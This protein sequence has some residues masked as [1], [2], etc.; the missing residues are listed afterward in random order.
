MPRICVVDSLGNFQ[1]KKSLP[2]NMHKFL[3][4]AKG[5]NII[6][7]NHWKICLD[8]RIYVLIFLCLYKPCYT[9]WFNI[10]SLYGFFV[11]CY[12]FYFGLTKYI[13]FVFS[14]LIAERYDN[15]LSYPNLGYASTT[16]MK[17]NQTKPINP[18]KSMHTQIRSVPIYVISTRCSASKYHRHSHQLDDHIPQLAA[19]ARR[20]IERP[21]HIL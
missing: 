9:I 6:C 11:S 13:S 19:S 12:P 2:K 4:N 15:Q 17:P 14:A 21:D 8:I 20:A 18:I 16:S 10:I 5:V 3:T 7:I 1:L